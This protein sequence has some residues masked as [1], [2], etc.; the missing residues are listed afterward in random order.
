MKSVYFA[1]PGNEDLCE[2]IRVKNSGLA[3]NAEWLRFPDQESKL[4]LLTDVKGQQVVVV[5]SLHMPDEK[6]ARL[7][8]FSSLLREQGAKKITLVSP[9]LPYMRQD[10]V[11]REGE[12]ISA[13]YCARLIAMLADELFTV[14]PHLHRISSLDEIYPIPTH[15]LHASS[16]LATWIRQHVKDPVLIGPDSESEQWVSEVA[17]GAGCQFTVLEKTR[18]GDRDVQIRMKHE[19]IPRGKTPV[20]VDDIISSGRTMVET[21]IH[22]KALKLSMP[23][24]VAVHAVFA[25][26][27]LQQIR[28]AGAT[29]IVTTNAIAHPTNEIDISGLFCPI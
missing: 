18:H 11:F 3:G 5:C 8:L 13:R 23:V 15:T 26:Q 19:D 7:Y 12:G 21:I 10:K 27:S 9:Y 1:Y 20:L 17:A 4:R 24:C 2:K 16:Y 29:R 28:E 6:L 22:L 25:E 14:D